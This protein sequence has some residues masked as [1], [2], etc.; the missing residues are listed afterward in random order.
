MQQ[1][2]IMFKIQ[3]AY[4]KIIFS[5]HG[6][7][8]RKDNF[9]DWLK[10]EVKVKDDLE[11]KYYTRVSECM[12]FSEVLDL[13]EWFEQISADKEKS[14][15]IDFIEPEL[16]FEYQNKKLTVLLCYDIAPVS[17]GEEPYQLTFSLDDKTLAM[18]IK[19]LGEAVASFKKGIMMKKHEL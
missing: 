14:T 2:K 11:G 8:E 13:L 16:A 15:E 18:I 1:K 7:R 3:N 9:E 10:V 17:Y 12:L 6:N 19:E 4:Q 5:I